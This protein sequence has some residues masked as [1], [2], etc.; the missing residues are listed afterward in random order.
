ML[1]GSQT[2]DVTAVC[3]NALAT[4]HR[5]GKEEHECTHKYD[6]AR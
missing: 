3:G 2:I 1:F 4:I 5:G 6:C